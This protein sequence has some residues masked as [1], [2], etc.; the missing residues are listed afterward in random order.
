MEGINIDDLTIEQ[1][2]MLTQGNQATSVVNHYN[3]ESMTIVEYWGYEA[4]RKK[5]SVH[6]GNKEV[7]YVHEISTAEE[8]PHCAD[9]TKIDLYFELPP[10]L[11]CFQPIPLPTSNENKPFVN[12]VGTE[13]TIES[14][15]RPGE[16]LNDNL[17]DW[18]ETKLKKCWKLQQ[19]RER[20]N[21]KTRKQIQKDAL[22]TGNPKSISLK[23]KAE[24][25][26]HAKWFEL[27]TR[28]LS[29]IHPLTKY[30]PQILK[31][32]LTL[33]LKCR[34]REISLRIKND[35]V[36]FNVDKI[37][38][39]FTSSTEE[40]Y[41]L[42]SLP[43]SGFRSLGKT[44]DW[45]DHDGCGKTKSRAIIGTVVDKL[46]EE[47]F[48]GSNKDKNDLEGIIDYLEPT[49]HDGFINSDDE[50]YNERRYK[51][52]GMPYKKPPLILEEEAEVTRYSIGPKEVYTKVCWMTKERILKDYCRDKFNE[53]QGD[54][55]EVNEEEGETFQQLGGDIEFAQNSIVKSSLLVI[56]ILQPGATLRG[57]SC[58]NSTLPFYNS[59]MYNRDIVLFKRA[60]REVDGSRYNYSLD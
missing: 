20:N 42:Q 54:M 57:V 14:K 26:M 36:N 24:K 22:K 43:D 4:A 7:S 47:W 12:H 11:P 37:D 60:V 17:G 33:Q 1:Y 3:I 48:E 6:S 58:S 2:L 8:Y 13:N 44:V 39:E 25:L 40:V 46:H 45:E 51:L 41:M 52:L 31:R 5:E 59:L 16:P 50:A 15:Q 56:V 55:N 38:Y 49:L 21:I 34:S 9:N 32:K 35:R 29:M 18:F 27:T 23:C 19:R 10:L 30:S 28:F 53:E